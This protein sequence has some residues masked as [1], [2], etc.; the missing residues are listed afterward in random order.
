MTAN[1]YNGLPDTTWE[2]TF[3][4][5]DGGVDSVQSYNN[6]EA[7]KEVLSLFLDEMSA[8]LYSRITLTACDWRTRKSRFLMEQTF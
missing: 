4:G 8:E 7:A 3:Y 1:T 5:K 6:E 2:L